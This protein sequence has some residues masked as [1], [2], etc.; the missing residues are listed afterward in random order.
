MSLARRRPRS[1][2]DS[3]SMVHPLTSIEPLLPVIRQRPLGL[4]SDI[5]GR[6]SPIVSRPEEATV[7]EAIRTLLRQLVAKGVKVGLITG[8]S[9]ETARRMVGLEDAAYAAEHGLSVWLDGRQETAPGLAEYEALARE[10]E[11]DL[12]AVCDAISGVQV[13]N[14]GALLAVHYRRAGDPAAARKAVLAAVERSQAGRR[15]RAQEGRMVIE[16]RPPLEV[17][18]GTALEALAERLSIRGVVC[19]GDDITDIDMFAAAR[20]LRGGGLTVGTVAVAGDEAAPEVAEAADYAVK[21]VAGVSRLLRE[22]VRAL[23]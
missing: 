2:L 11:H 4:M 7:P 5:D 22:M 9:L 23:P 20:R 1:V 8:R 17:D 10:A 6:L 15:F 19:L 14:K 3:R 21:G 12:R 13:E 18:K 16:L